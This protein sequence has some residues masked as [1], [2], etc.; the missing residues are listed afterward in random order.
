MSQFRVHLPMDPRL[1]SALKSIDK[2]SLSQQ[3]MD[4]AKV[5]IKCSWFRKRELPHTVNLI[6][7]KMS[8]RIALLLQRETHICSNHKSKRKTNP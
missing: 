5:L 8:Q 3:A 4:E 2:S 7:S 1:P 6:N